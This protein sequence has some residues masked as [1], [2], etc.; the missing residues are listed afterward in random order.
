MNVG[1]GSNTL[2]IEETDYDTSY[3]DD[4]DG[5][6]NIIELAAGENPFAGYNVSSI[7]GN[8]SEDGDIAS[9]SFVLT[10]AP[11][12]DV[13]IDINSS[14]TNEGTVD[15][16]NITFTTANWDEPQ[17]L[18]VTGIDDDVIDGNVNYSIEISAMVST[19]A[20]YNGENPAD[21]SVTNVDNDSSGFNISPINRSTNES[22]ATASFTAR[23]NTQP[24][25]D[26]VLSLSSS[27]TN[28]GT[29]DKSS[30]TFTIDNWNFVQTVTVTGQ[31]DNVLDGN[32]TYSIDFVAAVSSDSN[33]NNLVADSVSVLNLD[34]E[35]ALS[36]SLSISG[37]SSINENAGTAILKATMSSASN[38]DVIINLSYRGSASVDDYTR[39]NSITIPGGAGATSGTVEINTKQ[40]TID[41][42]DEEIIID[43]SSV[44]NAL[45]SGNQ[46]AT[47][48]IVDDDALPVINFNTAS[49]TVS[50]NVNNVSVNLSLVNGSS[51][52]ITVPY[53]VSGTASG[54]GVD[55]DLVN[56][57]ITFEAED[58]LASI[59]FLIQNDNLSEVDEE[60]II[61]LGAPT[62]ARNGVTGIH[63]LTITD[64]DSSPI[65]TS[66]TA[67]RLAE[68]TTEINYVATA[69]DSDN[70]EITYSLSGGADQSLF[71]INSNSGELSI[72]TAVDYEAPQDSDAN[73]IYLLEITASDGSNSVAQTVNITVDDMVEMTASSIGIKTIQF[74]WDVFAGASSYVLLV[75]PDGGSGFSVVQS[76]I[77]TNNTTVEL[78]VHLTDWINAT[79]ILEAYSDGALLLS[80]SSPVSITSLMLSSIGYFKADNTGASDAFGWSASVSADG[81]TL[82]VAAIN[83]D[84]ATTGINTT[85]DEGANDSGAVYVFSRSGSSWMQ[86]AYIKA[87]NTGAF[88]SFG[89][90]VSVS[91]D[92]Y[93]LAVGAENEDSASTNINSMPEEG[94]KDS[95][96]V[97][98]Y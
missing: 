5:R 41:E 2:S 52:V 84:S 93:I 14:D 53:T 35:G 78:P 36:V 74:D 39:I 57:V 1:A 80:T 55:H 62:N 31:D 16:D 50:E 94:A 85:P 56:G 23:L 98:V 42:L 72:N 7:S 49:Q 47:I 90:S 70:D 73:N 28:E 87:N 76:N 21:V 8:T 60:I 77:T 9:F 26:V 10:R 15:K 25:D 48:T 18:I 89:N 43:V 29:I 66:A 91:A 33:Y 11:T 46:S 86:Q 75:N 61:T 54:G 20:N 32:Q 13:S 22:G 6:S 96:A 88:D 68:N 4:N 45:E 71:S 82:A 51:S 37:A 30:L 92:G 19:D 44:V 69:T 12:A 81:S 58:T 17:T 3:D 24:T 27:N 34:N 63:K 67:I 79:Y 38:Q 83:E 40:D 95:G 64:N 97:Y 65:F 59:V